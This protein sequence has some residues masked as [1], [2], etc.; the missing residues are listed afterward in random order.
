MLKEIDLFLARAKEFNSHI[1]YQGIEI[2]I[3]DS[4]QSFA[5]VLGGT[6]ISFQA[7]M[8]NLMKV[9]RHWGIEKHQVLSN[10]IGLG[11]ARTPTRVIPPISQP[12]IK[13]NIEWME[14][15][16]REKW[17]N[18]PSKDINVDPVDWNQMHASLTVGRQYFKQIDLY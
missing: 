18:T 4:L 13:V 5:Y 17:G 16:V 8:T 12:N 10:E 9:N 15:K 6:R 14:K 2:G 7:W 11:H 1:G 3:Q